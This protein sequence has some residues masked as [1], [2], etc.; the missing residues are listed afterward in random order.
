MYSWQRVLNDLVRRQNDDETDNDSCEEEYTDGEE[1]FSTAQFND[2]SSDD[3]CPRSVFNIVV[4]V[5]VV[6][7]VHYHHLRLHRDID[8]LS[9]DAACILLQNQP[10]TLAIANCSYRRTVAQSLHD[11]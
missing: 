9:S 11:R 2:W 5:V 7:A 8:Q 4:I 1:N 10:A 3:R 6:H